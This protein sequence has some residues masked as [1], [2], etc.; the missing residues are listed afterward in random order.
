MNGIKGGECILTW[1]YHGVYCALRESRKL[2]RGGYRLH[3]P[4]VILL[5]RKGV[6]FTHDGEKRSSTLSDDSGEVA[7]HKELVES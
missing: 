7:S 3:Y 4:G 6:G 5:Y 2:P 1:I